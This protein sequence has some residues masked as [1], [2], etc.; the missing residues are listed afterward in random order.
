MQ[1]KVGTAPVFTAR[2]AQRLGSKK[3]FCGCAARQIRTCD[4]HHTL[5]LPPPIC[6]SQGGFLPALWQ[7]PHQC[8]GK[9]TSGATFLPLVWLHHH[10]GVFYT[11]AL[12][13]QEC[14]L[15]GGPHSPWS[16]ATCFQ[17]CCFQLEHCLNHTL[18]HSHRKNLPPVLH[19]FEERYRWKTRRVT[20]Q[21]ATWQ[22]ALSTTNYPR[23]NDAESTA[24]ENLRFRGSKISGHA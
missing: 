5:S 20:L 15:R 23:A 16:L 13:Q 18:T 19:T 4:R 24:H 2:L 14:H 9:P 21:S 1:N 6:H 11:P 17:E 7:R 12:Q 8:G 3:T 22:A 10:S